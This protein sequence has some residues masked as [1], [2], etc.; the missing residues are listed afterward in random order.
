M[1]LLS[2]NKKQ[3]M[4][5][6]VSKIFKW[7][8]CKSNKSIFAKFFGKIINQNPQIKKSYDKESQNKWVKKWS[9]FGMKPN[10]DLYMFYRYFIGDNENIVPNDIARSYIEPI[11]TPEEYQPFYNDKNS[12]GTFLDKG[13]MPRTFI[14]SINGMLY[15]E[16]YN[17]VEAENFSKHLETAKKIIVKPSKEMGGRGVSLFVREGDNFVDNDGNIAS[18]DYLLKTY[19]T[20]FLVQECMEQ[21]PFMAQ[22]NPT[23]VNTLRIA[24]YRNIKNGELIIMGAFLRIGGKGAYIDNI[25]SG[26]S[27]VPIDITNGKL[28][29]YA[30]DKNR[31]KHSIYNDI[32]FGQKTF[33]IPNWD[34]VK[35]FVFN[36]ARRMPHM[37]LFANDVALDKNGNP[38][39]IEVNTTDFSYTQY[40]VNGT[41]F[42]SEHTD[43]LI[44]YCYE[45]NKELGIFHTLRYRK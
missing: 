28:S 45:K 25:T 3:I 5:G 20:N 41:P 21:S 29:K 1:D 24:V 6:V 38:K 16:D 10:T 17:T 39:L 40:Q 30:C 8:K 32:D 27:S 7:R 44:R 14:R 36:V 43:N 34:A 42:F 13:M 37:N 22:F 11:L 19:K 31:V 35:T 33:I 18:Y 23:S 2:K 9:V 12:F 4:N 26:G 15:D